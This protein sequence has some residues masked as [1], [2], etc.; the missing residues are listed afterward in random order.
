VR[1]LIA[2]LQGALAEQQQLASRYRQVKGK[3]LCGAQPG[4]PLGWEQELMN[5][6]PKVFELGRDRL[7][8]LI[9]HEGIYSVRGAF[10][11]SKR[12]VVSFLLDGRVLEAQATTS[13]DSATYL[14]TLRVK[15]IAKV[16]AR[17]EHGLLSEGLL[18]IER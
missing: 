10:F 13:S 5:K 11:G 7:N 17:L 3:W 16:S 4:G 1:E 6:A 15:D 9:R 12:P 8:V 18:S 2:Q 14:L